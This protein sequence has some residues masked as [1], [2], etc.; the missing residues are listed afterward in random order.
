MAP[1][2]AAT[3]TSTAL[4]PTTLA[5]SMEGSTQFT[6][7]RKPTIPFRPPANPHVPMIM[8]GAGTGMAPFRGFLQERAAMAEQG[9]P[10]GKSMLYGCGNEGGDMLYADELEAFQ[11]RGLPS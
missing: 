7:V 8:V 5:S 11:S 6:F 10:V 2:A 9:V 1:P 3:A 4:P